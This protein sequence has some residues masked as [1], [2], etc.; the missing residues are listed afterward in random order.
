MVSFFGDGVVCR[1]RYGLFVAVTV[2]AA[3]DL[4]MGSQKEGDTMRHVPETEKK[5]PLLTQLSLDFS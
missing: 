1:R 3:S 2:L 4:R 5:I